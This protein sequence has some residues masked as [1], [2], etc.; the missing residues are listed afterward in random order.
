MEKK[1]ETVRLNKYLAECGVCSRRDGDKLI[2]SGKVTV[3]GRTAVMGERVTGM[4]TI[5]VQGKILS[6]RNQK[7]VL[8][9][10]KP[11]GVT[12]TERDKYAE[13]TVTEEI[14]YPVRVTYAGRLDKDSEGLLL[15]SND[16]EL[17][18]RMMKA[19]EKHEKEYRVRTKQT[20]TEEFLQKMSGGV[21]LKEL[22]VTTR[23]CTVEQ[24]DRNTFRIVLTQGLNRQIRRM[25]RELGFDVTALK[26][27]RV[28]SVT[29][30]GLAPGE[31]R[32]LD[33]EELQKLYQMTGMVQHGSETD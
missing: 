6:G 11:V 28:L 17:I 10:Y 30:D 14:G 20:L 12:C 21:Y 5:A 23:P 26:R 16:G 22:D 9:Y 29:L 13:K 31:Y 19:S 7:I 15:L 32:E 2:A 1:Q 25:C 4:E 8:A 24:I 33:R 3:D 18:L 27:V